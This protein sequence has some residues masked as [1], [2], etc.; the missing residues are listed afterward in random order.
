MF[1]AEVLLRPGQTQQFSVRLFNARGQRLADPKNATFS[2]DGGKIAA[3]GK[4]T[5]DPASSHSAVTVQ[6]KVGELTGV[7][8]VRVVPE[9]PWKFDFS[10]GQIP[11]TWVGARYRHVAL[12]EDLL[13]QLHA[14]NPMAAQLYIYFTSS[15]VNSGIPKQVFDNSTPAQ[16]WTQFQR[17][18][19]LEFTT[20]D[21]AKPAIDPAL[22]VL[23][24]RGV[25][26]S[27]EWEQ[28]PNVGLRL[29]VQKGPYKQQGNG[30]MTKITTIPKG[31]RSRC[32]FGHTDLHDY[33]IVADV[34]GA[35]KE[36]K[37]PDMGVVAQ[38]YILELQ[39][40]HQSVEIATWPTQRRMAQRVEFPWKADIW[41]TLKL[42]AST[43]NGK[44]VLRGKVWVRGEPEP[45]AWTVEAIDESP[46]LTGSPGLVGNDTNAE[47]YI[48]NI[49]VMAN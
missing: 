26:A 27:R 44:A 14:E 48:D 42:R 21:E 17:F 28:V 9:L 35:M 32:S 7:A 23:V 15:F 29:T 22:Q 4:F 3:D 19:R 49:Q 1:P 18:L 5:A 41:Y 10:S 33:T 13:K 8:R 46:N 20:V 31:T 12:D 39:G 16:K 36:A 45:D 38:G 37:Q 6:A 43:E 47:I 40:E 2:V 11:V 34:Q 25:L 24:D 30:V